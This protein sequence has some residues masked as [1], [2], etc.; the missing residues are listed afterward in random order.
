MK[1]NKANIRA[2]HDEVRLENTMNAMIDEVQTGFSQC[3]YTFRNQGPSVHTL[4]QM[5]MTDI[6]DTVQSAMDAI[7]SA[8]CAFN[9]AI[10]KE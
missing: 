1:K 9:E 7:E 3:R 8:G 5:G 2:Y 4:R 6:A 10:R